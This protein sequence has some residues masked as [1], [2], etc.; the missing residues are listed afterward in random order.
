MSR[1]VKIRRLM[2]LY[3]C[4]CD[5]RDVFFYLLGF[6]FFFSMLLAVICA[7]INCEMYS[8]CP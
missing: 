7:Q 6:F 2:H 5:I 4:M 8:E 3:V 1:M